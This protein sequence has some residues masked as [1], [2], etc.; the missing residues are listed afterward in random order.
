MKWLSSLP[1]EANGERVLGKLFANGTTTYVP[2]GSGTGYPVLF[3][4]FTDLDWLA[5]QL[6]GGKTLR[7]VSAETHP[8]GDP[9]V[10]LDNKIIK[11]PT[12][13]LLNLFQAWVTRSTIADLVIGVNSRGQKVPSPTGWLS[14]I[15]ISFLH[16]PVLIDGNQSIVL[17]YFEDTTIP[18]IRR[19][20]DEIR[21]ID[22]AGC[23]GLFLGRAHAR[24]CTSFACGEVP[25]VLLDFPELPL[26]QTRYQ[27]GFWTYFLLNF[28]QA[29]NTCDLSAA[30]GKAQ[31]ALRAEGVEI[32]LSSAPPASY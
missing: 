15:P 27:W 28:G 14:P 18:V 4:K 17:N 7:V 2:T 32:D 11:T 16:D 1:G 30:L 19:I 26:I 8:N 31:D 20:L 29:D 3:D 13:E 24:R 25:T 10:R 5:S 12:G 21:E 6:W 22:V 23:K 9:M